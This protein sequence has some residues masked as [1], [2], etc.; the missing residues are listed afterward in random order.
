MKNLRLESK[1]ETLNCKEV[2][3]ILESGNDDILFEDIATRDDLC[4]FPLFETDDVLNSKVNV[5]KSDITYL[6]D[7]FLM[8]VF[9]A[10]IKTLSYSTFIP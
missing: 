5:V 7:F 1:I 4:T 6:F 3:A 10:L 2:A 9:I 8:V